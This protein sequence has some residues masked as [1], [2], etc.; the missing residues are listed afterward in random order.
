MDAIFAIFIDTNCLNENNDDPALN[1]LEELEAK[2]TI[3]IEK[4]DVMDT[5]LLQKP[6]HKGLAKSLKYT[7]SFGPLVLGHSRLGHAVFGSDDDAVRFVH[8]L[9]AL[10]GKRIPQQYRKQQIRDAMHLVTAAKY[11]ANFFVTRDKKIIKRAEIIK[12]ISGGVLPAVPEDCL[13]YIKKRQKW[14]EENY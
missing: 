3:L 13:S 9:H 5:E 8:I 7:E 4:A 12:S 14:L 10:F 11:G 1:E 2:G 6:Y